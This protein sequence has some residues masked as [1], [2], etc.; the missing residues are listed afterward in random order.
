MPGKKIIP[1]PS[2]EVIV[3]NS[4][5]SRAEFTNGSNIFLGLTPKFKRVS[6]FFVLFLVVSVK[7]FRAKEIPVMALPIII[8][9]SGIVYCG[10]KKLTLTTKTTKKETK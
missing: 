9:A 6:I 5:V 8:P 3:G 1:M 4:A 7:L 10:L 2:M